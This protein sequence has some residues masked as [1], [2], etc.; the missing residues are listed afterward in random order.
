MKFYKLRLVASTDKLLTVDFHDVY[1]TVNSF[2]IPVQQLC[3]LSPFSKT[4]KMV[5]CEKRKVDQLARPS[6]K[7]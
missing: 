4:S 3:I 7:A 5:R 1:E 2:S 6:D